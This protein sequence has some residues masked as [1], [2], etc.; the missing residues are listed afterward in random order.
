MHKQTQKSRKL[1]Q[2]PALIAAAIARK[3]EKRALRAILLDFIRLVLLRKASF[4]E[5]ETS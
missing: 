5:L 4:S 1:S 2:L 3:K